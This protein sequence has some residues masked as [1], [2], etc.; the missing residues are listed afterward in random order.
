MNQSDR[1]YI[2]AIDAL[3]VISILAVV[4]IHTTTRTIE[5]VHN[6]ISTYPWTLFLN[7][8]LRF[9]VPLFIMVSGFVLELNYDFHSNYFAYLKKRAGKILVPYIFWSLI[10]YFF[11]YNSNHDNLLWVFLTGNASYQLYFIPALTI[12]YLIFPLLHKFYKFISNK[13]I[14][15][16]LGVVELILLYKDYFIG[17]FNFIDPVRISLLSYFFFVAGIVF[18]KNKDVVV[19][20]VEKRKILFIIITLISGLYVFFEGKIDYENTKNYLFFYSQWRP[21]VLIYTISLFLTF[22][23]YFDKSSLKF[24][25]VNRIS[26]LSFLVFFIHVIVLEIIWKVFGHNLFNH[27]NSSVFGKIVFDPIFFTMVAIASFGIAFV[28]HKIP[29]ISKIIG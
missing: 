20:F 1:P 19:N 25:T 2:K 17:E 5:T 26:K 12:F 27:M 24:R 13:Y 11:V 21:S 15:I 4:L 6:D 10:Y 28:L 16:L 14:F 22:F 3:R 9:A 23:Y 7:Q 18:A 8:F 29:K